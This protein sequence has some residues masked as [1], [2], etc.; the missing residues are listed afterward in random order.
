MAYL[1]FKDVFNDQHHDAQ[2]QQGEEKIEGQM[3]VDD[4]LRLH[5]VLDEVGEVL[6]RHCSKSRC[7]SND[8]TQQHQ[9]LLVRQVLCLPPLK[10]VYEGVWI[11]GH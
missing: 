5:Q 11:I 8:G 4:Q 7:E 9:E 3:V 6:D 10:P 1:P 2:P